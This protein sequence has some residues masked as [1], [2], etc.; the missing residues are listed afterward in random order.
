MRRKF[1]IEH[2]TKRPSGAKIFDLGWL[3][4]PA[5]MFHHCRSPF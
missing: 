3:K 4:R 1:V 2:G 5:G